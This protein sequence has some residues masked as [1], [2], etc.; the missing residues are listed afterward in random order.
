MVN[1]AHEIINDIATKVEEISDHN[2]KDKIFSYHSLQ[3][4]VLRSTKTTIE[5]SFEPIKEKEYSTGEEVVVN[6]PGGCVAIAGGLS[7]LATE[8]PSAQKILDKGKDKLRQ[9]AEKADEEGMQD[10]EFVLLDEEK[11][12]NKKSFQDY[13]QQAQRSL[14]N[15]TKNQILPLLDRVSSGEGSPMS[16]A[17]L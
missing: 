9:F 16:D 11:G 7:L 6:G 1:Q 4:M 2:E 12:D 10:S 13:A 8:F 17:E 15:L 3:P 5:E 14:R